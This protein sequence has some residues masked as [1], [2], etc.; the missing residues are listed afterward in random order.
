MVQLRVIKANDVSVHVSLKGIAAVNHD[1]EIITLQVI[2]WKLD[3]LEAQPWHS[4]TEASLGYFH[5]MDFVELLSWHTWSNLAAQFGK[6]DRSCV[7]F[8]FIM[9]ILILLFD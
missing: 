1:K 9:K 3:F 5:I 4:L 2:L 8:V 7:P 6:D